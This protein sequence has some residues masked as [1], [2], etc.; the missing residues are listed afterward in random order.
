MAVPPTLE[1]IS[2]FQQQGEFLEAAAYGAGHI[3]DTFASSFR[4]DG[5]WSATSTSASIV[6]SS[7]SRCR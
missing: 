3:N 1:I 7:G 5:G 6:T 2:H 4:T